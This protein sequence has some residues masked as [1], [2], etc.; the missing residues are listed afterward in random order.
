MRVCPHQDRITVRSGVM[1]LD[2][3]NLAHVPP[4]CPPTPIR[5]AEYAQCFF[6]LDVA[7]QFVGKK[8]LL[9]P[10]Q[11]ATFFGGSATISS[12]E[13]PSRTHPPAPSLVNSPTVSFAKPRVL[14]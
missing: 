4:A 6:G 2:L 10:G 1:D 8:L 5:R 14:S 11:L 7:S 12:C 3:D 9:C 13:M